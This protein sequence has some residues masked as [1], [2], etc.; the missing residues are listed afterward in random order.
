MNAHCWWGLGTLP[1]QLGRGFSAGGDRHP[2]D[3]GM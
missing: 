2:N 3:A 1:A